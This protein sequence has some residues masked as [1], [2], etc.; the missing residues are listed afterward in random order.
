M[1]DSMLTAEGE[2]TSE[3]FAMSESSHLGLLPPPSPELAID[4]AESHLGEPFPTL[5]LSPPLIPP[6]DSTQPLVS[7]PPLCDLDPLSVP[8]TSVHPWLTPHHFLTR[9]LFK[10][11]RCADPSLEAPSRF[12]FDCKARGR[13]ASPRRWKS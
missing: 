13:Q 5:S 1:L 6:T 8:S 3:A 7:P 4:L 9:H 2:L 10:A 12:C 11:S